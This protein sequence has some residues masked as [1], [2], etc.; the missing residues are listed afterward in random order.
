MAKRPDGYHEVDMVMQTISL[1]DQIYLE[2]SETIQLTCSNPQVPTDN[3]NLAWRAAELLQNQRK[4]KADNGS[5]VKIHIEKQIP[6][7][8]GLAGGSADAA[9]VLLGL[10]EMWDLGLSKPELM[11]LGLK[12]GADVPFCIRQQT[13]RAEGIGE[14]LTQ[15]K[16]RL[17]CTL[18]LITPDIEV[19]TAL[20]YQSLFLDK[21][22]QNPNIGGVIKALENGNIDQLVDSWGNVLEE[23]VLE[24]FPVVAEIKSVC[25]KHGLNKVLM[26]GSGPSV[27]ALNPDEK[28]VQSIKAVL[29]PTWFCE[30]T[31]F[32][33]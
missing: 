11:E 19:S 18:L 30:M 14:K 15:I 26:S 23:V 3:R 33:N 21:I 9:A 6:M 5:G 22:N 2:P 24:K 13:A 7:A 28:K 27:Y 10:N 31:R 16:S 8:A 17:E 32:K 12:L 29:P 4:K 1:A 20:V 25:H